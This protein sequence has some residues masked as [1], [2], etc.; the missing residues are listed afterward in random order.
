MCIAQLIDTCIPVH[1]F[2]LVCA[3]FDSGCS[4]DAELHQG[5]LIP[6]D[7]NICLSTLNI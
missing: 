1:L 3:R 6:V 2:E 4:H 7:A 5:L